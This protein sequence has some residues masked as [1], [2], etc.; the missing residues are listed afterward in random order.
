MLVKS[1]EV[2]GARCACRLSSLATSD[3]LVSLVP[4]LTTPLIV[5]AQCSGSSL[6]CLTSELPDHDVSIY[7]HTVSPILSPQLSLFNMPM[8]STSNIH[9]TRSGVED[10]FAFGA[11]ERFSTTYGPE[12]HILRVPLNGNLYIGRGLHNDLVLEDD[13]ISAYSYQL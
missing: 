7:L 13:H 11:L 5:A 10:P 12:R 2:R 3:H 8:T 9:P 1:G 6:F 4:S